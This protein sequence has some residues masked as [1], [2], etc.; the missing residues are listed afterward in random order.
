[1][2]LMSFWIVSLSTVSTAAAPGAGSAGDVDVG[3]DST[4][5]G[6]AAAVAA[7]E[8][9]G[10]ADAWAG[11]EG[12]RA[13]GPTWPPKQPG[14]PTPLPKIAANALAGERC[15]SEIALAPTQRAR[16]IC[17]AGQHGLLLP[18]IPGYSRRSVG[19]NA[20]NAFAAARRARR[21]N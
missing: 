12:P 15:T 2:A 14:R 6:G 11:S 10:V 18:W 16:T 4:A 21:R 19:R 3:G 9:V 17:H 8:G 5:V 1:M 13:P 7:G 20:P